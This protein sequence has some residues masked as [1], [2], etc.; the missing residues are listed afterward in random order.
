MTTSGPILATVIAS[1]TN[2][3]LPLRLTDA[4]ALAERG[5]FTG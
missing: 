1:E 3:P 2:S 4:V 5:G